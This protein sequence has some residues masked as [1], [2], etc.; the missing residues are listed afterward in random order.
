MIHGWIPHSLRP[1]I[2]LKTTPSSQGSGLFTRNPRGKDLEIK[3]ELGT[4]T[5]LGQREKTRR[6]SVGF[7]VDHQTV[8]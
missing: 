1:S 2:S 5:N 7:A 8:S 4:L 3:S 6:S